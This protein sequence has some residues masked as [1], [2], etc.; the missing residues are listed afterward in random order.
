MTDDRRDPFRVRSLTAS[1]Y[2]PNLLFEIGHGATVPVIALLAL[3]HGASTALAGVIVALRGLGTMVFDVPA[4]VIVSRLGERRAMVVSAF[5]LAVIALAIGQEPSL[6][7]YAL[8]VFLMGCAWAMW[9]LSRLTYA[10]ESSPIGHRGRV[11]SMLG[12]V[13]RM[14]S[15][16]ALF[17]APC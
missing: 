8:L 16:S 15:S 11:M 13:G 14:V 4:G 1:V 17:S 2:L 7:L 3:D 10:T 12:G 6:P 5:A 9:M